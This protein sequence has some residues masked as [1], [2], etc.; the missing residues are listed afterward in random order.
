MLQSTVINNVMEYI[1][2]QLTEAGLSLDGLASTGLVGLA[3]CDLSASWL[4]R[5]LADRVTKL[6][7]MQL[8]GLRRLFGDPIDTI[9]GTELY[10]IKN[11]NR[12]AGLKRIRYEIGESKP[13]T[14]K[15]F[16]DRACCSHPIIARIETASYLAVRERWADIDTDVEKIYSGLLSGKTF[17]VDVLTRLKFSLYINIDDVMGLGDYDDDCFDMIVFSRGRKKNLRFSPNQLDML[18]EVQ[19]KHPEQVLSPISEE[20]PSREISPEL[21]AMFTRNHNRTADSDTVT[22]FTPKG[23]GNA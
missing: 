23:G 17:S 3:G 19:R 14:Q 15:D 1:N 13:K 22:G 8:L 16:A 12:M 18:S 20:E 9:I 5:L 21:A 2:N 11:R 4:N 7:S 6:T 10:E